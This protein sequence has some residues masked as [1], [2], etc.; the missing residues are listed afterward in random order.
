MIA[1]ALGAV[2]ERFRNGTAS[3]GDAGDLGREAAKMGSDALHRLSKEVER[4]PLVTLGV[5]VG[6]GLLVGLASHRR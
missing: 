4:R 6:V 5:A 2:M 3:L 1:S